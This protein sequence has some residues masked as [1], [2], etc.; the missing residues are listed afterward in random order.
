MRIN[1]PGSGEGLVRVILDFILPPRCRLCD[2]STAGV[3]TPWICQAC[4]LA[5]VYMT[6][7]HCAQC[8][9]P[10]AAPPESIASATHRCGACLL[11]PPPYAR[12]R[13]V[14]RYQ[15]VLQDIIHAMKYQ[16]VYGL[17]QPL[18]ELLH[19][20]FA[21][22]WGN[23]GLDAL[24]P[25]PLHRSKLRLREFD[26]A[27]ALATCLSSQGKLPPVWADVL[28]RQRR[29]ASQVGLNAI[30]RRRNVRGAFRLRA[31]Q[32]CDGKALL[33]IDDVYTTGATVQECARLLRR[34]GATWVGVYTL[35]RV[36]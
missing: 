20:Q 2:S 30:E 17:V 25:V 12:A 32:A 23:Q 11:H 21:F 8:G 34:A 18:A 3:P 27:L 4:W 35:A 10:L 22:H 16:R 15:G 31:P 19:A 6:P 36:G 7:P 28:M 5:V 24:I 1:T 9:Q 33:L 14:G 13:A 26:Q 29:T